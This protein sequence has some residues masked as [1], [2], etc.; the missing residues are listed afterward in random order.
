MNNYDKA[1]LQQLISDEN[2]TNYHRNVPLDGFTVTLGDSF[3]SFSFKKIN[4]INV[5]VIS[6]IHVLEKMDFIH[7]LSYCVKMWRGYD[8]K[9]VYYKEHRRKSNIINSLEHL[10]FD[11]NPT[12]KVKWKYSWKSTNG[13]KENDCI[14][15][16]TKCNTIPTSKDK[17]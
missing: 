1:K 17:K 16:Y 7:L 12:K 4:D 11:V 10:D 5:A 14:E 2:G 9:M 15:A 8:V 3:I 6:Y 13:F